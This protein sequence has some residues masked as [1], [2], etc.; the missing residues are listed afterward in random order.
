MLVLGLG[1]EVVAA[2]D[3]LPQERVQ[4]GFL[5]LGVQRERLGDAARE[6]VVG[7]PPVLLEHRLDLAVLAGQELVAV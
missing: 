7:L 4:R 2:V 6:G 5:G 3:V 1:R